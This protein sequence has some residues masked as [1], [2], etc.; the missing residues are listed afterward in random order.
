MSITTCLLP[1]PWPIPQSHLSRYINRE[2]REDSD[3][4]D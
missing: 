1:P 3:H 4:D 2:E